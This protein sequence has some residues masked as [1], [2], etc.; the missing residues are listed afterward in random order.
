MFLKNIEIYQF[1]NYSEL[2]LSLKKGINIIYGNNG[3][4]KTNLLESIYVLAM[5]KSHRSFI[6]Q[7]LIQHEKKESKIAGN[8]GYNNKLSKKLEIKLIEEKKKIKIDNVNV[9]KISD[10]I[11]LMNL[12][13][14]YPEDLDLIK[15][16]PNIRRKYINL[17]LSQLNSEYVNMYNEYN[18][19]L[20]M[21]NDCLKKENQG[22]YLD[23]SYFSIINDY[24]VKKAIQI[25]KQRKKYID[26]INKIVENIYEKLSSIKGFAL[27]YKTSIDLENDNEKILEEKFY[28]KINKNLITEIKLG[29]TI[30]GPHRDDIE[31]CINRKN[32]KNFS[33]QGQQRMAVLA[34]KIA[35]I[36]LLKKYTNEAP[37]LL[38]DDVFSEL[39]DNKKNNLLNYIKKDLQVIITTTDLKNINKE[40]LDKANLI[41][42]INGTVK[43]TQE[44]LENEK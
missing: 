16:S 30:N 44:E 6:D 14:F 17:E 5:T 20:K 7:N 3:E 34:I 11:S 23:K 41:N 19:I 18:K 33:S 25:Y 8:I 9:R 24:F 10:Y 26:E 42:I 43:R 39:D 32:M 36:E 1:R 2:N 27:E 37:I 31:F 12:I 29:N 15:G 28:E 13:I 21:R 4:G 38:L 35:E 40:L 22:L